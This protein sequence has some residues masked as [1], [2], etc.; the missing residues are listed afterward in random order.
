MWL[1]RIAAKPTQLIV[2]FNVVMIAPVRVNA[3]EKSP[4]V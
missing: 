1:V 4:N 2:S 3:L